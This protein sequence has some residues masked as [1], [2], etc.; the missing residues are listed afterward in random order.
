M[1]V[2]T[3]KN[4]STGKK[5]TVLTNLLWIEADKVCL[6]YRYRWSIGVVF[7][8]LKDLLELDHF[9]SRDPTGIIRQVVSALIVWGLLVL[10]NQGQEDL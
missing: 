3:S 2:S 1:L 4:V 5:M 9:I 7:R 6:L 8:G 10:S